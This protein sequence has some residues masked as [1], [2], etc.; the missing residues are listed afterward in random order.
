ME[1]R[2]EWGHTP[3]LL[4]VR[5]GDWELAGKLLRDGADP[6]AKNNWGET[7]AMYAVG[8]GAIDLVRNLR[9]RGASFTVSA[10]HHGA[11]E[12]TVLHEAARRGPAELVP[13]LLSF[14]ADP[15]ARC[16]GGDYRCNGFTPLHVAVLYGR[17][18]TAQELLKH[19][20]LSD[21]FIDAGLGVIPDNATGIDTRD[22]NGST[23]LHWSISSGHNGVVGAIIGHGVDVEIEDSS[24]RSALMISVLKGHGNI[25]SQLLMA[26]AAVDIFVA[27]LMGDQS[28]LQRLLQEQSSRLEE[29][30][31]R[32]W[33]P[34][35]FAARGGQE[36]ALKW[37]LDRGANMSARDVDGRTPLWAAAYEARS[38]EVVRLLLESGIDVNAK[39][40][41]GLDIL[42]YD[43]GYEIA[44]LLAAP[45]L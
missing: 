26:G 30:S 11:S 6:G 40:N 14:G 18:D 38:R 36:A 10:N 7:A 25:T 35:H 2:D 4:A 3:L 24:G 5:H 23:A 34:V 9:D 20:A 45:P 13:V 39:D 21:G 19:G 12:W 28:A 42:A 15:T 1:Q 22:G 8:E 27:S 29:R 37:L 41:K 31:A 43:V 32:D 33:T 16:G 17:V 44:A